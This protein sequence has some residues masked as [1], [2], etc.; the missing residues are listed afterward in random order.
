M[1]DSS[2]T[3]ARVGIFMLLVTV[4][5]ITLL[6][7]SIINPSPLRPI[8][9]PVVVRPGPTTSSQNIYPGPESSLAEKSVSVKNSALHLAHLQLDQSWRST[10]TARQWV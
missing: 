6:V 2:N 1:N 9:L 4:F 10:G 5:G 8:Y 7:T 3:N